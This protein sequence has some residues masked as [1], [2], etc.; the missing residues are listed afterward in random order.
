[1]TISILQYC[2]TVL[3][4]IMQWDPI[5]TLAQHCKIEPGNPCYTDWKKVD[6]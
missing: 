2:A 1:M 6:S 5:S 3:M 4:G